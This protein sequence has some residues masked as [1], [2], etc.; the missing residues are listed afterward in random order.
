MNAINRGG[1]EERRKREAIIAANINITTEGEEK[2]HF[3]IKCGKVRGIGQNMRGKVM[4]ISRGK[5]KKIEV[6]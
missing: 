4:A 2:K 6:I 5:E 1:R 3:K